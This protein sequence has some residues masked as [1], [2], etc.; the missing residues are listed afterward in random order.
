MCPFPWGKLGPHVTQFRL[1]RRRPSVPSGILI[2]PTVW[3]Q[4]TN[5]V[6]R[7]TGQTGQR[8]RSIERTVTCNSRPKRLVS[9]YTRARVRYMDKQTLMETE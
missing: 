4:Y 2:H 3:P 8:S 6:H 1:G 9:L 5:I 7:Q